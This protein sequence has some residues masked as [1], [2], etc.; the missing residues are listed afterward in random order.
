VVLLDPGVFV[1]DVQGRSYVLRQ[2]AGPEP[3][4]RLAGDLAIEDQLDFLRA[5]EIE[6]LADH[7]LEEQPA[8]QR[9]IEHLGQGELGLQDRDVIAVTGAAIGP[10]ERMRQQAQPLAQQGIDLLCREAVADLLQPFGVSA[11]QDAIVERLERNAS[12]GELAFGVFVTVQAT[13]WH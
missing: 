4:R 5:S 13:A 10:G 9:P 2:D 3:P 7:L 11:A 8:V 6:V 1:I 12:L